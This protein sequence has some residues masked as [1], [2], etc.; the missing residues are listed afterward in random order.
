[1]GM[2]GA[3]ILAAR[4]ALAAG[5]R[6]V[7]VLVHRESLPVLQ[8]AVPQ[9]LG[10]AWPETDAEA[11]ALVDWAD[12]LVIGPG[13]GQ[14]HARAV[15][16]RLLTGNTTPAVLDADALNAFAGDAAALGARLG[17]RR[18]L[19]TPHAA[20]CAR[21]V[22]TDVATVLG[23]RFEIGR[24]LARTIGA[25]VLLK[26]VPTVVSAPEGGVA[27]T[28]TGTPALATGGSGDVLAGLAGALIAHAPSGADAGT[29]AAWLHGRAAELAQ[30][31]RSARSI[32]LDDVLVALPSLWD[33]APA[34]LRAPVLAELPA[35]REG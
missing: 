22:G 11:A 2:A 23:T 4:A 28:A 34:S 5:A 8:S 14:A 31:T 24:T 32:S 33:A 6:M 21:L 35:V 27:V 20:E 12:A 25:A 19:V 16:D 9:A 13:L 3:T 18:A 26:G 29:A 30:G 1:P 15:V 10:A 7:Q 17:A